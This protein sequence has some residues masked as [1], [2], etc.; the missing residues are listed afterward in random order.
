[1]TRSQLQ[2]QAT[3]DFETMLKAAGW[4]DGYALTDSEIQSA[5]ALFWRNYTP[6]NAASKSVRLRYQLTDDIIDGADNK[7]VY[8]D[9]YINIAIFYDDPYFFNTSTL[10]S[11]LE[12]QL[13]TNLWEIEYGTELTGEAEEA[14][15]RVV[16]QKNITINKI[17]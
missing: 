10:L 15:G 5:T 8:G 12:T 3:I 13:E 7:A 1:M 11:N 9:I 4:A 17:Y 2:N 16:Y 6:P 14:A